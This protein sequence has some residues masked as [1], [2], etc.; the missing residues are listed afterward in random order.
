[1]GS[2][3]PVSTPDPW[4]AVHV[5]VNRT[6]PGVD[7]PRSS[8]SRPDPHAGAARV[9]G[10][11]GLDQ[12]PRRRRDARAG[13]VADLAVASVDPFALEPRDLHEVR[14]DLTFVAGV[15]VHDAS[16]PADLTAVGR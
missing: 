7:A 9:H 5:A 4:Q 6:P 12:P 14:T 13:A 16:E 3:W 15:P 8:P 10:G 1:M 2:D 11:L